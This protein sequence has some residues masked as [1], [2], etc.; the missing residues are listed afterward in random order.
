M[1]QSE[2]VVWK[3]V[4]SVVDPRELGPVDQM[5][6]LCLLFT[7]EIINKIEH[8]SKRVNPPC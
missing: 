2:V 6:A 1:D 8:A 3:G 5:S 4:V 7:L